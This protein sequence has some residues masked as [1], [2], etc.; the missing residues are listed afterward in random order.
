[1]ADAIR[2]PSWERLNWADRGRCPQ[3]WPPLP[4]R[5]NTDAAATAEVQRLEPAK[6][7]AEPHRETV[8]RN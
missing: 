6:A 3:R 5:R 7:N 8:T 2:E 4:R 1:M